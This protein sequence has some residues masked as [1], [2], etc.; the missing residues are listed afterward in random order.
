MKVYIAGPMSGLPNFNRDRF[1]EIAGLVVESGNIPLNPAI[2]PDGLPERDYMAIG[3]AML[4]CVDAIYLIEGWEK[5]AGARAE[6]ALADKLN[7]PIIRFL[8]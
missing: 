5:S 1:N 7:I 4:Q 8:I 6:K 2:L 3:I